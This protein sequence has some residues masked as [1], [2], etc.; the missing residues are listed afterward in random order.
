MI[1]K[2]S[3][4]WTHVQIMYS[5]YHSTLKTLNSTQK[6]NIDKLLYGTHARQGENY[7]VGL[8]FKLLTRIT[9]IST[10]IE[11]LAVDLC[12]I[13][14]LTTIPI[15]ANLNK[16]SA[17][18]YIILPNSSKYRILRS[19]VEITSLPLMVTSF[20]SLLH[21]QFKIKNIYPRNRP[22]RPI[23]L[24]DVEDPTLSRQSAHS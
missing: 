5:K 4:V 11:K 18:M 2:K 6:Q 23:G 10:D 1:R 22:W 17:I 15:N 7:K 13:L 8:L 19:R 20:L 21:E 9:L 3:S 16:E 24:R 12:V 14:R